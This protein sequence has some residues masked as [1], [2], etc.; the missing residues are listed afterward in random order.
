MGPRNVERRMF[1]AYD[2]HAWK[3]CVNGFSSCSWIPF[4]LRYHLRHIQMDA[5]FSG[6]LLSYFL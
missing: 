4:C 6:I 2:L 3:S 1:V 5:E